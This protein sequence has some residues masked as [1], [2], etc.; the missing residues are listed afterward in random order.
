MKNVELISGWHDQDQVDG[1]VAF[2]WTE[3][4]AAAVLQIDPPLQA[5]EMAYLSVRAVDPGGELGGPLLTVT[6]EGSLLGQSVVG[7]EKWEEYAF[8]LPAPAPEG[9][10]RASL[11][12][13]L[14]VDRWVEP[15]PET[16]PR[17][18]GLPVQSI[19][20]LR[21]DAGR[22]PA[23]IEL[24]STTACNIHPPCV[25]CYPKANT[26]FTSPPRPRDL[27]DQLLEAVA[28][29]IAEAFTLSIHGI[30]EPLVSGKTR[31]LL[32]SLRHRPL[33]TQFNSNGLLL[34]ESWARLLV[35]C[36]L[37][38]ICFSVD[39]AT[40]ETYR[41]IRHADLQKVVDNIRRLQ[42]IKEEAG[43]SKPLVEMNMTL[44]RMNLGEAEAFIR[45]AADLGARYAVFGLLNRTDDYST[46]VDG[47]TFRY[48]EQMIDEQDPAFTGTMAAC[49]EL[50]RELGVELTIN[51]TEVPL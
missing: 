12:V 28:P 17:E 38:R 46:C 2:R 40:P 50:A 35:D 45:L 19:H 33:D 20:L 32:E 39:A 21:G 23:V 25:M 26:N 41:R 34:S 37:N 7:P 49:R 3:R 16:D 5:G 8:P 24:E 10:P 18:F 48:A 11:E 42:R 13:E 43:S 15:K 31:E 1:P 4:R 51:T 47:F 36:G 9:G 6:A 27:D 22:M 29:A 30:G 14:S 44:M